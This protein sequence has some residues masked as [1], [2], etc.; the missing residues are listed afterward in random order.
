MGFHQNYVNLANLPIIYSSAK[1][2]PCW[3]A[4]SQRLGGSREYQGEDPPCYVPQVPRWVLHGHNLVGAWKEPMVRP[5][6]WL[7][8]YDTGFSRLIFST[9]GARLELVGCAMG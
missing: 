5:M 8:S 2:D 9:L 6:P 1:S 3:G 7:L 4:T